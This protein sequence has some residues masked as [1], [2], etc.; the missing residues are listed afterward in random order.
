MN[1]EMTILIAF[2]LVAKRNRP[3]LGSEQWAK[4]AKSERMK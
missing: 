2:P 4:D 1:A 3:R